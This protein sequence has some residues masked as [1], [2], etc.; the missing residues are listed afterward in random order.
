MT[1]AFRAA[2]VRNYLQADD[3]WPQ[4]V[5]CQRLDWWVLAL[6]NPPSTEEVTCCREDLSADMRVLGLVGLETPSVYVCVQ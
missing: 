4:V 1:A 3:A 2:I 5:H 6:G